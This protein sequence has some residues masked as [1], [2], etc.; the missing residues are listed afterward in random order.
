MS[1]DKLIVKKKSGRLEPFSSRK[2]ARAV[3]RAGTPYA[4]ALEITRA[5]KGS[6]SLSER[7]QISSLMLRKMVAEELR[8]RGR[9]D[10]AKSYLGYKK[11][12]SKVKRSVPVKG[13][14]RKTTSSHAKHSALTK[15]STRGRP[16]RW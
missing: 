9:Q 4:L 12:K 7:K 13:K 11:T 8:Q 1:S 14:L 6:N 5:V 10:I 15:D 2:M 16:P 3:S